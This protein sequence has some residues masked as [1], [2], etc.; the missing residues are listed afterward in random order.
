MLISAVIAVALT[1]GVTGCTTGPTSTPSPTSGAQEPSAVATPEPS[2]SAT[3][4]PL[5]ISPEGIGPLRIGQ[6]VQPAGEGLVEWDPDLCLQQGFEVGEP[7]V[8]TWVTTLEGEPF[9][10]NVEKGM[11]DEN[12]RLVGV[13]N[14][15]VKTSEG[16]GVG[17]TREQFLAAHPEAKPAADGDQTDLFQIDGTTGN[18][19]VEIAKG[20]GEFL[21]DGEHD[22][23]TVVLM[24]SVKTG[25]EGGVAWAGD[26]LGICPT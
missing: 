24:Y 9:F 6:P 4:D 17:S 20:E 16:I 26:G 25:L 21:E 1:F 11:K 5:V 19:F 22:F 8:G 18:L 12:V 10:I 13:T 14:E 15:G 3:P 2:E 23:N 7:F